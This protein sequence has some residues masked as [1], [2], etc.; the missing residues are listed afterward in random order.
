MI[1]AERNMTYDE[2]ARVYRLVAEVYNHPA[3]AD[4]EIQR[5]FARYIVVTK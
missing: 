2:F 5:A 4:L 3:P 1:Q